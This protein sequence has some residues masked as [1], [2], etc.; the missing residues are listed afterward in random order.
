MKHRASLVASAVLAAVLAAG[1]ANAQVTSN[2]VSLTWTTPGDDGTLGTAAQFDLRYS[3]S[4][5]TE[6]NFGS[7]QRWSLTPTPAAPG[8]RQGVTVTG[9]QA[10]TT[11]YFA[12][13]TADESQNWSTVSNI[14]QATTLA[15]PDITRPAPLAIAVSGATDT[16]ATVSWNAVGDDSLTGV[17]TSYD[18]R[19]STSPITATNWG[20]ATQA[21]GEPIPGTP[22]TAQSMAIRNLTRQQTYYFAARTTDD[23]GNVSAMS[24]VPSVTTPDT[25]APAAIRDLAVGWLFLGWYAPSAMLTRQT[26]IH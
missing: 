24:N 22:G 26:Q 7:A 20:S 10:L 1:A 5:I 2:S 19:Y 12:I 17:A 3:T 15:A 8:T 9:L 6:T 13:K 11:Y 14:A 4:P 21:T 25:M 23:A 16:T 18:V